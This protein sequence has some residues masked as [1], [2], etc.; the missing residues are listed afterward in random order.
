MPIPKKDNAKE[1]NYYTIAPISH[2]SKFKIILKILQ[3]ILQKYVNIQLQMF[4]LD[5][6]KVEEQE[7]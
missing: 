7:I 2:A 5:L 6:K 1:S 4:K 3:A